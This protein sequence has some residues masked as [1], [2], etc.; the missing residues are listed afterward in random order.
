MSALTEPLSTGAAGTRRPVRRFA[1]FAAAPAFLLL[2]V[3]SLPPTVGALALAFRNYTLRS[4]TTRWVGL[5]NF[6]RL[7]RDRRLF[8]A[9]EVSA[10]WEI[11]TVAGCMVVA[12]VI[13]T[14]LFEKVSRRYRDVICLALILPI[15]LPRVSAGLI[16]R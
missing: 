14:V 9:L 1:L 11:A 7:W 16:W 5:D 10:V 4:Q 3:L 15:L 6:A 12:I 13:G 8:N 2:F